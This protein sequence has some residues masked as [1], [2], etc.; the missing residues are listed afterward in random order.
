MK[1]NISGDGPWIAANWSHEVDKFA[2]EQYGKYK[3]IT[4]NNSYKYDI[5]FTFDKRRENDKYISQLFLG[6][7]GKMYEYATVY[8]TE[9]IEIVVTKDGFL[10]KEVIDRL[11]IL[12][13]I[14]PIS[15]LQLM[16]NRQSKNLKV[17]A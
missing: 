8:D 13:M 12:P 1:Q 3:G 10:K 6:E 9:K 2:K 7:N 5:E 11:N 17:S 15:E 4:P 14:S 16:K